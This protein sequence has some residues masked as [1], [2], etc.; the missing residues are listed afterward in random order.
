MADHLYLKYNNLTLPELVDNINT[1]YYR[2]IEGFFDS[3]NYSTAQGLKDFIQLRKDIIVP[4]VYE[5]HGK[6]ATGHDCSNCSG[7]CEVQHKLKTVEFTGSINNMKQGESYPAA[8]D[9]A[10]IINELLFVEEQ[11]LLPKIIE[12]QKEINVYS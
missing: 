2:V 10:V 1:D 12:A 3:E 9:M 6:A 11:I 5:L 7:K 4:Y 8:S